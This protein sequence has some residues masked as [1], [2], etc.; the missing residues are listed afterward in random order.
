MVRRPRNWSKSPPESAPAVIALSCSPH[1]LAR[2][3]NKHMTERAVY[4]IPVYALRFAA[5]C[6]WRLRMEAAAHDG[7][8]GTASA[9]ASRFWIRCAPRRARTSLTGKCELQRERGV[10]P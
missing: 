7:A 2:R 9:G 8:R 3:P 10:T 4:S 1:K 5:H 6:R